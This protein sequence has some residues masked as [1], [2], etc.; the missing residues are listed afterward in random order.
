VRGL[1]PQYNGAAGVD[2]MG[3]TPQEF[4]TSQGPC[5]ASAAMSNPPNPQLPLLRPLLPLPLLPPGAASAASE[6]KATAVP[7]AAAVNPLAWAVSLVGAL[8][9][10]LGPR[11]GLPRELVP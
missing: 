5:A 8:G 11:L 4:T 3:L 6:A 9:T 10:A 1:V 2:A 7:S